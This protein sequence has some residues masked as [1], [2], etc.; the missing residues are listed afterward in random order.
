M[1]I[2]IALSLIATSMVAVQGLGNCWQDAYGR[3]VGKPIH[4]C[5]DGYEQNGLL[6]YPKCKEGYYGVG[7]VC[8]QYCPSGFKDTGVDCLKPSSYGRGAGY[9]S[10]SSCNSHS[11]TGCEKWGLIW[12][13]VCREGFHNAACC[14][15]SPNC[16]NGQIDIGVSCQ[17]LTYGRTAGVPLTCS[18]DEQYDAG[19]CYPKCKSSYHGIGPVCW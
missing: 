3:G 10:E 4:T 1:R 8:W 9:T 2:Q 5:R 6:C 14:V 7:P 18:N 19:L 16:I 17:K 13:P 11:S 12:Y 15:C